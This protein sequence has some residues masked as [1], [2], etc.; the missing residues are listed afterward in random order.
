M[1]DETAVVVGRLRKSDVWKPKGPQASCC[2]VLTDGSGGSIAR[3][4]VKALEWQ[5]VQAIETMCTF[6]V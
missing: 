5:D 2:D 3:L 1:T 4:F 6:I